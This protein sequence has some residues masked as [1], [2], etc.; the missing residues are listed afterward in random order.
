M[1]YCPELQLVASA[2]ASLW[3]I[4]SCFG[5][6]TELPFQFIPID[7][8]FFY[9]GKMSMEKCILTVVV[10]T[11]LTGNNSANPQAERT[12]NGYR[13]C[14]LEVYRLFFW[15]LFHWDKPWKFQRS[16]KH[17]KHFPY[18]SESSGK[19]ITYGLPPKKDWNHWSKL[20]SSQYH[21]I[22]ITCSTILQ[23]RALQFQWSPCKYN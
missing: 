3:F 9:T 18:R 7:A 16:W 12:W 4:W 5:N 21:S 13:P 10:L 23:P 17:V 8:Q 20:G 15:T 6:R 11:F 2:L 1:L 19:C 14:I 22:L